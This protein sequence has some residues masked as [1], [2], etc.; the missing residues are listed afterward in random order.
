MRLKCASAIAGDLAERERRRRKHQQRGRAALRRH[1]RDARGLD[2]AVGPDAIDERQPRA[3]F[4]LRDIE[5]A[6][7]LIE[8]A[9]GHFGRM[10]IDGDGRKTFDRR[11]VAQMLAEAW[12]VDRRDRC[13]MAAALPGSRRAVHMSR[14]GPSLSP[15]SSTAPL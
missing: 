8:G 10:R 13:R 4:I 7:L 2:A 14:A 9:G 6:L 3:D 5:N 1:A 11:D 12:L 15:Y